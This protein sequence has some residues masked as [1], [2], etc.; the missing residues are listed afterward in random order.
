[1]AALAVL[2]LPAAEA[3]SCPPETPE[4]VFPAACAG[5]TAVA[6][7]RFC[8]GTACD[9]GG[10]VHGFVPP[11]PPF[12]VTGLRLEGVFG[13]RPIS[14]ADFPLLLLPSET[15]VTELRVGLVAPG[16]VEGQLAWDVSDGERATCPTALRAAA[17]ACAG[18]DP[19]NPCVGGET[20][21]EGACIPVVVTG[22]CED[23]DPC[24]AGDTCADGLC[25]AGGPV[26][27][28][29]GVAC[30]VDTCTPE[31]GCL[32]APVDAL[33]GTPAACTQL[34]CDPSS[35]CQASPLSGPPCDDGDACT[36]ADQCL[37]G[38]CRGRPVACDDGIACTRDA[39][40]NGACTHTPLDARCDRGQC[41]VAS[42]RPAD[43]AADREGCVRQPASEGAPCTADEL[44]CTD[45]VCGGGVCLHV[46]I[47]SRCLAT[48]VCTHAVCA[49]E[50][51]DRDEAG[52]VTEATR[53]GACAEDGDP[54]TD[55]LCRD[56]RC[57]HESV[58]EWVTCVPVQPVFR[59][60][61]ALAAAARALAAALGNQQA[62]AAELAVVPLARVAAELDVVA[63]ILAG[64]S[65][66][67][68]PADAAP[69]HRATPAQLRARAAFRHVAR[70]PREL[71]PAVRALAGR[72][73]RAAMGE[74]ARSLRRQGRVL[75][76]GTKSLK[77]DL[78]RLQQVSQTFAR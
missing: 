43:Q 2:L 19:Q 48:D 59:T 5:E 73:L 49:P 7:S 52:C 75:L 76:R 39:C 61:L 56:G 10:V 3:R 78:K 57:G 65:E 72:R 17:P 31:A 55:D 15:L 77:R 68:P 32:H 13:T 46:P 60:A 30:T 16:P 69:P 18:P 51:D 53:A 25:I 62:V 45:D 54:C 28:D 37:T 24:T 20:C 21:V 6:S 64:K 47:D 22:P 38:Q 29:D 42:C 40:T 44:P 70:T 12:E 23:G 35:G 8:L 34:T 58:A 33:C 74:E 41:V 63:A 66:Q 71:R 36:T 50:R 11:A 67:I 27:C 1:V 26:A 9:G 4:V 14:E